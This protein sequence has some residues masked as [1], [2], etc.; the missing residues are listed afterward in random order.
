MNAPLTNPKVA[1]SIGVKPA[2]TTPGAGQADTSVLFNKNTM[3]KLQGRRLHVEL[4]LRHTQQANSVVFVRPL[5]SPCYQVW[6]LIWNILAFAFTGDDDRFQLWSS[7]FA[8]LFGAFGFFALFY[9]YPRK[10]NIFYLAYV[11]WA[12][13][14]LVTLLEVIFLVSLLANANNYE[15]L[16]TNYG[17]MRVAYYHSAKQIVILFAMGLIALVSL[18]V[19][20]VCA[21]RC[22]IALEGIFNFVNEKSRPLEH[23]EAAQYI[24]LFPHPD[25]LICRYASE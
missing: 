20:A 15:I 3:L 24:H 11:S 7:V 10:K 13:L 21:Q 8:T 2:A 25:Y 14:F 23:G 12:A 16:R 22:Q 17:T 5:P 4:W 1:D 19:E 18:L 9:N 6:S